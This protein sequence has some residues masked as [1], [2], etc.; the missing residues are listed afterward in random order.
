[1]MDVGS[2]RASLSFLLVGGGTGRRSVCVFREMRVCACGIACN[3]C[4]QWCVVQGLQD[5]TCWAWVLA[6]ATVVRK[7]L[8]A[9][10]P[11]VHAPARCVVAESPA[12]AL[13]PRA[14]RAAHA[15]TNT[16]RQETRTTHARTRTRTQHKASAK[17]VYE[18]KSAAQYQ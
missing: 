16:H 4:V 12:T 18:I 7:Q 6:R 8:V 3:V 5:K 1:V 2:V 11:H 15:R 10:G 14:H 9:G 13:L 17:H